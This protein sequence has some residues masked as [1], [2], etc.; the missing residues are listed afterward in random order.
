MFHQK[1]GGP[2]GLR[3]TGDIARVVMAMT[4][5]KVKH[6][7]EVDKIDSEVRSLGGWEVRKKEVPAMRGSRSE[8][9]KIQEE[10]HPLQKL[11]PGVLGGR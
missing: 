4:D 11:L 9:L 6:K 2:I 7:L 10:K 3:S 8:Q 5:R 1:V